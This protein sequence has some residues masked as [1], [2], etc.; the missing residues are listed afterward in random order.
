MELDVA[1]EMMA[2]LDRERIALPG[3]R[4][5]DGV[6]HADPVH[7]HLVHRLVDAQ[8]V[9]LR[10]AEAVLAREADLLAVVLD[11]LD[12][13]AGLDD[14]LVHALPVRELAKER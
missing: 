6:G 5:A 4:D 11:E 8:E 14:D 9:P 7:S 2:K 10:G 13:P 12:D 1:A 3:R